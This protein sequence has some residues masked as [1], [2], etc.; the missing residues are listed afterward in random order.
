MTKLKRCPK[1]PTGEHVWKHDD[2]YY[3]D[4]CEYCGI[5]KFHEHLKLLAEK[6]K[7]EKEGRTKNARP[8]I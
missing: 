8:N 1:S 7:S 6:Y 2:A 3:S 5:A 4:F